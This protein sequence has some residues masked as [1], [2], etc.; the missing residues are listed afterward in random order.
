MVVKNIGNA[1]MIKEKH[2]YFIELYPEGGS[3]PPRWR[4]TEI[5]RAQAA[6]F[7]AEIHAWLK[8]EA[9]DNRVSGMTITALGQVQIICEADIINQIRSDR[10]P[11]IAMIRSGA[12][13][14]ES[15]SRF[16]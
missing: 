5:R 3:E 12:E 9:L 6:H 13:F 7:I 11:A 10:E 15:F 14:A 2:R 1:L 4:E 16:G 8:Q